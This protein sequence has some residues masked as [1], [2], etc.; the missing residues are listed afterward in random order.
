MSNRP[1]KTY[2]QGAAHVDLPMELILGDLAVYAD[3]IADELS[4]EILKRAK[5]NA[6]FVDRSGKLRK[7]GKRRKSKF[8]T[9]ERIVGFTAP[10]AHLVEHGHLM[11]K[12]DGTPTVK[13]H[14]PGK[15]FLRDAADSVERDMDTIIARVK[16]GS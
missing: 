8:N 9:D 7:S 10:H 2:A 16:G 6:D 1:M 14:V 13:D 5:A 3:Q 11:L 12:R 4:K 15:H